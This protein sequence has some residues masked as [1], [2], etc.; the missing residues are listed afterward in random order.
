[1]VSD[2][3]A[4]ETEGSPRGQ[5]KSVT[6]G[7]EVY[8]RVEKQIAAI[9]QAVSQGHDANAKKFLR[10]LIQ[11]QTSSSGGARRSAAVKSA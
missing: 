7:R 11:D 3:Q 10:E 2:S 1:M 9:A 5:R 4:E 8:E 6:K